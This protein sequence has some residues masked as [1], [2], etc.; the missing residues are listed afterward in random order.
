MCVP[1]STVLHVQKETLD[2]NQNNPKA[3]ISALIVNGAAQPFCWDRQ[4]DQSSSLP[5]P[6]SCA[7]S[8]T[9]PLRN[10]GLL[11]NFYCRAKNVFADSFTTCL[12]SG[13]ICWKS[14]ARSENAAASIPARKNK[15]QGMTNT[16]VIHSQSAEGSDSMEYST[17]HVPARFIRVLYP[18]TVIDMEA[19]PAPGPRV[20]GVAHRK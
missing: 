3:L 17:N 1:Q 13:F 20:A 9:L 7:A 6:S 5:P 2:V 15:T 8:V 14:A 4:M 19:T 11:V 12:H 10:A 16:H 18:Q